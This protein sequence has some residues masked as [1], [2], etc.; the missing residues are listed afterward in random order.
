MKKLWLMIMASLL[1][2]ACG[3][4]KPDSNSNAAG[5]E[6]KPAAS[7]EEKVKV[8][9]TVA[10]VS[11]HDGLAE[12]KIDGMDG[13]RYKIKYGDSIETKDESDIYPLP[14]PGVKPQVKAGDMVAAKLE[15]R[16][17][18]AGSE[19]LSVS[20]DVI[21]VKGL[22]YGNTASVAPDKIIVVRSPQVADFKK[23][24]NEKEF[25][26]KAKAMRPQPPAG[27]KP[28]VGERV[29][30]EWSGGSWWVA[31]VV[32]LASDTAKLK[33]LATFP[34]SDL[35]FSKI[36]PYPK[37]ATATTMPAVSSYVLVKPD[38]DGGQWDYAQVTAV[39]GQAAD[40]K[41][42]NG[43]TRSIKADEYIAL[44]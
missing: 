30:A 34:N 11:G 14:K 15:S 32:S 16:S 9:D 10:F 21:E 13:A 35:S 3:G 5:T 25:S 40:V 4:T 28:K 24:K 22:F 19:V 18:W 38:S 27:W 6:G 37:A 8:G 2:A 17:W 7:N 1:L 42:A 39:N 33:W 31:E 12:G 36:M 29:I 43:K 23:L 20:D 26:A 41:F 44:S